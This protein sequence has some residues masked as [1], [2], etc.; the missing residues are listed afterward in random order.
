MDFEV[1]VKLNIYDTIVETTK[2]PTVAEVAKV[3][4]SS[5]EEVREVLFERHGLS[6]PL[7]TLQTL[8]AR[9]ARRN[10]VSRK[11][12]RYFRNRERLENADITSRRQQVEREHAVLANALREFADNQGIRIDADEDALALLL[13]FLAENQMAV[14]LDRFTSTLPTGMALVA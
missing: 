6:V 8:L 9:A 4:A 11:Y 10:A 14:L 12:G 2:A 3:M 13:G 1:A 7:N 5:V